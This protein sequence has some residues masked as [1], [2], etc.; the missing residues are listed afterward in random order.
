MDLLCVEKCFFK[1][2]CRLTLLLMLPKSMLNNLLI[3]TERTVEARR[4]WGRVP[5]RW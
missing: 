5:A 3:L 1:D 4:N 2:V